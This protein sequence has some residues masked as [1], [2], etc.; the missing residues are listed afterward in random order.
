MR[1]RLQQPNPVPAG[2][3]ETLACDIIMKPGKF[4]RSSDGG[5]L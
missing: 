3:C 5:F 4:M 2:A 1:T